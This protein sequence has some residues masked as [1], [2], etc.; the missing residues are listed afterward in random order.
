MTSDPNLSGRRIVITGAGRGLGRA[1]SITAAD[2]GADV[3]LLGRNPPAL[4]AVADAIRLRTGR[5]SPVV[6]C[7]LAQPESIKEACGVVLAA[8]P[9]IDVLVN[10]AAPWLPGNIAELAEADIAATIAAAVTGTILVTKGLLPGLRQSS[11]ADII[12]IVSTAGWAGWDFD[13]AS[14]AFHAAKH[15]QSGFSDA[16]RHE[17]KDQAI[18]VAAIYPPDFDDTDPLEPDRHDAHGAPARSK[19]TNHE[20]VATVLFAISAP[21]CC[22]Y[23]VI[24]MDNMRRQ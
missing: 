13:G 22:A 15:G 14:A 17:L 10:N 5:D 9:A 12:T 1:L 20:V 7:D 18:R 11:A 19:L 8:A 24:I 6:P 16:L 2:H 23:P 21:R 3:V 4:H